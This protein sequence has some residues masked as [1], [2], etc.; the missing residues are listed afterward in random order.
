MPRPKNDVPTTTIA[1]RTERWKHHLLKLDAEDRDQKVGESLRPTVDRR[2]HK[3]RRDMG[4]TVEQ[5][6]DMAGRAD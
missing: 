2:A 6:I 4:L 5:A 3:I 1:V